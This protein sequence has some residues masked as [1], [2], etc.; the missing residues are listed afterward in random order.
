MKDK[1]KFVQ[2]IPTYR[3]SHLQIIEEYNDETDGIVLATA[4]NP[5]NAKR[6]A[7]ALDCLQGYEQLQALNERVR[8]RI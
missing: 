6:I 2:T 3:T 4:T 7:T 1:N 5:E 8:K